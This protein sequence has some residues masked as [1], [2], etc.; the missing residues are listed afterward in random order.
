[1]VQE[2]VSIIQTVLQGQKPAASFVET[3]RL[4]ARGFSMKIST[5]AMRSPDKSYCGYGLAMP[6]ADQAAFANKI[7]Y[8]ELRLSYLNPDIMFYFVY[9]Y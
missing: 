2:G 8:A 1:M 4:K 6:V 9:S 5:E 7:N 3:V